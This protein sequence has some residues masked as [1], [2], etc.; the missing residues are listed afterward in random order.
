[1]DEEHRTEKG[2]T[3]S[4]KKGALEVS[5]RSMVEND[6][7]SSLAKEKATVVAA[8]GVSGSHQLARMVPN[9]LG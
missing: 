4:V 1:M 7:M 9:T 2:D 8:T 5:L 6:P 3:F